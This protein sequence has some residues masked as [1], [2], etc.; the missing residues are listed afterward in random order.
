MRRLLFCAV[1][2]VTLVAP[3]AA[4]LQDVG[5]LSFPTSGSAA[6]QQH[7]LRGVAILHSFGWKQAIAEFKLAQ[8]AQPDFAM[9]YWGES[10]CYNHPLQAAQDGKNPRA[11]LAR[12]GPDRAARLA[13]APTAR[14]KGFLGAVEDLWA[15]SGDWRQRR[16]AY[17]RAM[18]RLYNQFP[19]DDEVTAFYALSLLSGGG[20]LEDTTNRYNNKGGALAMGIVEHNPKHPGATHY[21]IHAFDDPIH[22][23]LALRAARVYADIVPAV[24]HAVHMPTHIFIQHGMWN[25]VVNQNVRAYQI[26]LD[27]W[28]PGDV[29]GDLSHSGDW[30][31]YGF[32]QQG[33]Y[34]GARNRIEMFAKMADTTKHQ[35]AIGAL[36]LQKARYIIETEEWKVQP[37]ADNASD[38]TVF[39]NGLS[40]VKTGDTATAAKMEA[41]LAAKAKAAP[42]GAP[43]AGAHAD[44]GG[45]PPPPAPGGGD[46]GKG[47]RVMHKELAASIALAKGDKDQAIALLN[48]AVKIEESMRPPNGAADPIKPSHELLGEV[49][50]QA[51]KPVEAAEAFE[52][53][54]LRMPNRA[55]SLMGAVK[56]HAAAGQK[57]LAAERYAT[58]NSFWK[59]KPFSNPS[60]DAR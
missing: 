7:F 2:A 17:M 4:Q 26:A 51:G 21:I 6:A 57:E 39:A 53:S 8:Q 46:T 13:K 1:I 14:E 12:L 24:S 20:A 55:R 29:P 54:L 3:A 25:E 28:E 47:V 38:H 50:L 32:L 9:A 35:R 52:A 31:Q 22:A 49:L 19:K 40:A 18:E 30:G 45:A 41:L 44:H 42:G 60:T 43:D 36:A 15:E 27:L 48:D 59:G 33:D 5:Q 56:A 23:P 37:I 16:V 58:L 34:A 10:L 11:V